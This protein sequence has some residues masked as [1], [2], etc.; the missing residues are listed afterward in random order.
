MSSAAPSDNQKTCIHCGAQL[1][2]TAERCWLCYGELPNSEPVMAEL[3]RAPEFSKISERFFQVASA[4]LACFLLLVIVAM[5]WQEPVSGVLLTIVVLLPLG[6]TFM[7]IT[8]RK[9]RQGRVSWAERFATY[10]V[11]TALLVA[12][13]T[14]MAV[15]AMIA[16]FVW[17]LVQ[18]N[19]GGINFH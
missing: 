1:P 18:L 17:C 6:A 9:Q 7:R 13:L 15:A 11:S 10:L 3:V 19:N 16:F 8:I 12:L 14:A 5:F 2:E 4:L